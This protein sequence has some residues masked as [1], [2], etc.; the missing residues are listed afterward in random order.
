MKRHVGIFDVVLCI[1]QTQVFQNTTFLHHHKAKNKASAWGFPEM[2]VTIFVTLPQSQKQ[3]NQWEKAFGII[4]VVFA[5]HRPRWG[6]WN[7]SFFALPPSQKM[8]C[9]KACWHWWGGVVPCTKNK[10]ERNIGII[11]VVLCL[12][13][14]LTSTW[15]FQNCMW[16]LFCFATKPKK[17]NQWK[18]ACWYCPC[19]VVPC[20]DPGVDFS[21]M[22]LFSLPQIQT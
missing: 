12:A 22:Q 16:Q 13:R 19:G 7:A 21:N 15:G 17:L 4:G 5:L 18:K 2:C 6:L 20:A 11:G 10:R 1:V 9:K 8:L 3:E 14:T